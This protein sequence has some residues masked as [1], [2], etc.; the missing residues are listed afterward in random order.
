[1]SFKGRF[2]VSRDSETPQLRNIGR[3]F[4]VELRP[5]EP[6]KDPLPLKLLSPMVHSSIKGLLGVSGSLGGPK[7]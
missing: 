5:W 4:G 2:T 7:P 3:G 1:M 6:F